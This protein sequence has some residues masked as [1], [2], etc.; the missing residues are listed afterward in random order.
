MDPHADTF[1]TIRRLEHP[2]LM[3]KAAAQR[4]ATTAQPP[5][6]RPR[7]IATAV[8]QAVSSLRDLA[9]GGRG[10]QWLRRS[11]LLGRG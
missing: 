10:L 5:N 8:Q 4:L 6:T 1:W 9:P 7:A 3:R 11:S 2:E